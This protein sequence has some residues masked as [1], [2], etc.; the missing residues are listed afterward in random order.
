[1]L[2][3]FLSEFFLVCSGEAGFFCSN[4]VATDDGFSKTVCKMQCGAP[5]FGDHAISPSK[6]RPTKVQPAAPKSKVTKESSS[7]STNVQA[8]PGKSPDVCVAEA[9]AR[10][11][12]LQAALDLL[13]ARRTSEGISV[14]RG[15]ES[16]ARSWRPRS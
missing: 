11:S 2:S 5:S 9:Q 1:M 16:F 8:E 4:C 13:G 12:R 14:N 10:V 7:P 15:R 3:H 6:A